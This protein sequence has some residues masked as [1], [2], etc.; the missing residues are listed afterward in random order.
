MSLYD[1][2][3]AFMS[4]PTDTSK[5]PDLV[6]AAKALEDDMTNTNSQ[7]DDLKASFKKAQEFSNTL[8]A[9]Q[10][11]YNERDKKEPEPE[12]TLPTFDEAKEHLIKFAKGEI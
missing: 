6:N 12:D 8:L 7:M 1:D 9:Q 5:L 3:N 2:L 4:D 10:A 11:A